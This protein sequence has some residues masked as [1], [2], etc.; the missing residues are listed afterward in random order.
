MGGE[1][2]LKKTVK[3]G[4]PYLGMNFLLF[5]FFFFLGKEKK[6]GIQIQTIST[7]IT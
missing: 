2:T 4:Q 6:L 3:G 7:L 1:V 5:F